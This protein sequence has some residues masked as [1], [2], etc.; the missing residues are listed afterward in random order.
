MIKFKDEAPSRKERDPSQYLRDKF[1]KDAREHNPLH[2]VAG[3]PCPLCGHKVPEKVAKTPAERQKAAR[4]RR[5]SK[6]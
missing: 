3:K 4:L 2:A 1:Q 5:K 6:A